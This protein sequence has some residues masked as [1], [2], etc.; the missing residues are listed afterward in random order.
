[1]RRRLC[2]LLLVI[3]GI[4]MLAVG[5]TMY[6]R[7]LERAASAERNTAT[8]MDGLRQELELRRENPLPRPTPDEDEETGE[9][10]YPEMATADYYG[11]AMIGIIRVPSCGVE[12]PVLSDWS[13]TKLEYAPCRYSGNIYAGDF[14]LMGH[15]Y[16]C[17][18]KPLKKV[19]LGAELE[20]EDANGL[21]W[22]YKVEEID[23]I[24]RS[25]VEA[26]ASEHDLILFT[27]EEYGVYRFVARC[28][29]VETIEPE[30]NPAE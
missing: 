19:E 11:L 18:F 28:S 22:K 14:I 16:S 29:L 21:I 30:P 10:V 27:C 12:L 2:G 15:N 20:F 5:G 24:H 1:M 23:S 13:Y 8:L 9:I 7:H 6:A 4:A 3:M 17:H 26:L 25:D